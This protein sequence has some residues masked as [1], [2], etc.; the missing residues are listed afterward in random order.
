MPDQF[1]RIVFRVTLH[2]DAMRTYV[3]VLAHNACAAQRRA[4]RKGWKVGAAIPEPSR[5][6]DMEA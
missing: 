3:G 1:G 4:Q 2:R 5:P 6:V